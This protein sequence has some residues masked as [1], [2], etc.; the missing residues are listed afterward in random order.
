MGLERV[1]D[2]QRLSTQKRRQTIRAHLLVLSVM[3]G[4]G[5]AA[6][7]VW[8]IWPIPPL[9][10]PS[11]SLQKSLVGVWANL[12][13]SVQVEFTEDGRVGVMLPGLPKKYVQ[14]RIVG[15]NR[16]EWLDAHGNASPRMRA[17]VSNDTLTLTD[18]DNGTRL[19]LNRLAGT[20][21]SIYEP[22]A[23]NFNE[24]DFT[25]TQR[26]A[27][28]IGTLLSNLAES[29][30]IAH[31]EAVNRINQVCQ[32]AI[33]RQVTWAMPVSHVSA[34]DHAVVLDDF[35]RFLTVRWISDRGRWVHGNY[36]EIGSQISRE[37]AARLGKG[38][39]VTVH[40]TIA[41]VGLAG[42][43]VVITLENVQAR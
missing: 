42:S 3:A 26:W 38:H 31:Q 8:P 16:I 6:Y 13:E 34:K 19:V 24:N 12:E 15:R 9:P 30:E 2:R 20:G 29:N 21:S 37:Q 36:L 35:W 5:V 27:Q 10:W 33:G 39:L 11:P 40:G 7:V 41:Q 22:S 17:M 43:A 14:Y 32:S 1:A 25:Q 28:T 4:I 23:Q 18:L